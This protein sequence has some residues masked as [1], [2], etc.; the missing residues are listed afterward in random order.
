MLSLNRKHGIPFIL[1]ALVVMVFV[2]W[3]MGRLFFCKCGL[4]SIWSGDIWSNQNSQ[5]LIDPYSFTHIVHGVI[6]YFILW[7]I[8]RKKFTF[9]PML[10]MAVLLECSWEILENTNWIINKYRTQTISLDYYGDSILNSFADIWAMALGFWLACKLHWKWS[11]A[12]V[13]V[14]E[15]VLLFWIHDNLTLNIV[16]LFYPI[17]AIKTWQLPS[18]F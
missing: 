12:F 6:F 14:V 9:W 4:I 1:L 15:I 13:I 5:Q 10:L 16:M 11:L 8:F 18:A 2:E 17:E 7:L 3:Y